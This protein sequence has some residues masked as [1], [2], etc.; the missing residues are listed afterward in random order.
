MCCP[1]T[2][3]VGFASAMSA[4]QS[5]LLVLQ[6]TSSLLS[7]SLSSRSVV[8]YYDEVIVVCI[9]KYKAASD[10]AA[11]HL[12]CLQTLFYLYAGPST[13]PS[14]TNPMFGSDILDTQGSDFEQAQRRNPVWESRSRLEPQGGAPNPLYG[15]GSD[16][17]TSR[18][19]LGAMRNPVW[20]SHSAEAPSGSSNPLFGTDVL[21]TTDSLTGENPLYE[22]QRSRASARRRQPRQ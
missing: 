4:V 15:S 7:S 19:S 18:D 14:T 11:L 6:P 10:Y 21:D 20:E 2:I 17:L 12:P 22:T 3:D 5:T 16:I 9:N 8:C 13:G 1:V